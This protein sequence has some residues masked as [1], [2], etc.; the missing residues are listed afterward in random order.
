MWEPI[1]YVNFSL[2]KP[3]DMLRLAR[4]LGIAQDSSNEFTYYIR[5]KEKKPKILIRSNIKTRYLNI[6]T[7]NKSILN[8]PTD[9]HI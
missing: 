6:G 3:K 7:K 5:T 2:K 4:F 9:F 1:W 8:N